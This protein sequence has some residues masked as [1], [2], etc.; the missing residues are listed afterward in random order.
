MFELISICQQIGK[1]LHFTCL[2]YSKFEA[3]NTCFSG[4]GKKMILKKNFLWVLFIALLLPSCVRTKKIK[5]VRQS[6]K[7]EAPRVVHKAHLSSGWYSQNKGLLTYQ[8][9]NYF[10]L[11]QNNFYVESDPGKVRSL[12][13]PHAG[14]YYSGLCAA[15]AYQTLFESRNLYSK[16]LKNKRIKRVIL[17]APSHRTF[18]NGV[19]LPDYTTYQTT[20][21]EIDVDMKAW[22]ALAKSSLFKAFS[23]AHAQEHAVE[24]QLPFL[25]QSIKNFKIVPLI[26]GY[27]K[28][29]EHE[30][31]CAM[32]SKIIDD[33]TLVVVSSDFMHHGASYNYN[34]FDKNIL[35]QVRYVDSLAFEAISQKSLEAFNKVIHETK[36]TICG[37]DPIR[38]LLKLIQRGYLGEVESR[39]TCY[40]TS[41]HVTKS[42]QQGD[43]IGAND[44]LN[45]VSDDDA[46]TSVS[47]MGI[48][49]TTQD[50]SKLK[51]ENQLTGFEKKSLLSLARRIVQ[52]ALKEEKDRVPEHLLWPIKS[53]GVQQSSGAFVTINTKGGTLRGCIGKIA[54]Y[55]PLYE[56]I[57]NMSKAAAF[58]D[59]RFTPV[60]QKEF[61][62]LVFDITVLTPTENV[63]S[64]HEIVLGKHGI[65]L[66]KFDTDGTLVTSSVF[67]PSVPTSFGWDLPKTLEQLSIKAGLG[68]QGWKEGSQFQIFEGIEI[69]EESVHNNTQS[70]S[71]GA[72]RVQPVAG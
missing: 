39:L 47:Y 56:T 66:S 26:I 51:K 12:I 64:L 44:L 35:H 16:D 25:Q 62:N 5:K 28:H 50:L 49:F 60:I 10:E 52:N 42:R 17:L 54:S 70:P 61:N 68:P 53:S 46:R 19:A 31:V 34:V 3:R 48:I 27:L 23:D 22:H 69:K 30:E 11:A 32:L 37:Q 2:Q 33:K 63:E 57:I 40:Y 15:T 29:Y 1:N 65:I 20:L 58:R 9:N 7:K 8:I 41:P 45:N 71:Q 18:F 24:V 67:L 13:V 21:G 36:T 14:Y 55:R 6:T 4:E 43:T 38:I 59:S 72:D